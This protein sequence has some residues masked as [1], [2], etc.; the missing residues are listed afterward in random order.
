MAVLEDA[1]IPFEDGEYVTFTEVKG[2]TQLNGTEHKIKLLSNYTFSI[3][4]TTKFS[5]YTAGGYVTQ[6]KKPVS[7]AFV[8]LYA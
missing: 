8:T 3:D 5:A 1:K 7:I 4:D 2:M 6:V